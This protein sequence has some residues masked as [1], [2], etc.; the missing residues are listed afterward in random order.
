[1]PLTP[2]TVAPRHAAPA[3][4]RAG[5]GDGSRDGICLAVL[6]MAGTTVT[7]AGAVEDAFVQALCHLDVP[8]G[9]PAHTRMME[10]VR[11][12]MGESKISV[13]R[14]LFGDRDAAERAND[15]FERAYAELVAAGRCKPIPGARETIEALRASGVAVVL[16][17]GFSPRT[18]DSLL[19]SLGWLDLAD[20]VLSPADAG[21]GRPYPDMVLTALLRTETPSVHHTVVVGDT[22]YDIEAGLRAGAGLVVAVL[23]GAHTEPQLRA[24]GAHYVIDS[25][26]RLPDV[27]RGC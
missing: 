2:P 3:D 16:N 5:A 4:H 7:D 9:G 14:H 27:L 20:A 21:R 13:F 6:D 10:H 25:V 18:R 15:V 23:T 11:A 26:R 1:M 24:A 22:P 8:E 12:T 19:A 17:T